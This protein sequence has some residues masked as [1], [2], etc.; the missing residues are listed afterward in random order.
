MT[1]SNLLIKFFFLNLVSLQYGIDSTL[2]LPTVFSYIRSLTGNSASLYLSLAQFLPAA[3]QFFV[4]L[5]VGPILAFWGLSVKWSTVVFVLFSAIG[6]SLYSCAAE[7]GIGDVWA[8]IGGRL[9][10]GL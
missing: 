4:S 10:C 1:T 5:L 8:I 9:L 6:N 3:V 7:H 2:W